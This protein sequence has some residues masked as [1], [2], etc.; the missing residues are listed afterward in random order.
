MLW[1]VTLAAVM[2]VLGWL[3]IRNQQVELIE[4]R[5]QFGRVYPI[6]LVFGILL[7]AAYILLQGEMYVQSFKS[8][9]AKVNLITAT[10]LFLKRNFV[11]I[12]LPAGGFSSLAFFNGK[13][14]QN[15]VSKTQIHVASA[16]YALCGI[17]SVLV[18]GIPVFAFAL[19]KNQLHSAELIS[20]GLLITLCA[21][22]FF[23]SA[24]LL[25]KGW[26]FLLLQRW[27]PS[28]ASVLEEL[29]TQDIIKKYFIRTLLI[30]IIIE[31]VGVAHLYISML[32]FGFQPS[33]AAAFIGYVVMVVILIVSPL[34]RGLGAIEVSLTIILGQYGL[35]LVSAASITLLFRFFEFWLP[36]FA[37]IVSFF[38]KR[39]NLTI[40]LLPAFLLFTLAV[41]NIISAVTPA[42]PK[43]LV[44]VENL[45]FHGSASV[46]NWLVLVSGFIL[47][48]ISFFLF[49][50]LRRAWY[51]ALV[52]SAFSVIGHIL[53][54]VDFEEAI[55]AL[56]SFLCLAYTRPFYKLK[57]DP[58]FTK[59]SIQVAL[60]GLGAIL[61]YGVIGFYFIDQ[62]HFGASFELMSAVKTVLRMFFLFDAR[63]VMPAT[64]LGQFFLYSIYL[65]GTGYLLII[66]YWFLRPHFAKPFNTDEERKLAS[67]LIK[68][69]GKSQLDYFK[70]YADKLLFFSSDKEGFIS[71]KMHKHMAV[72]L[73]DPVCKGPQELK[74]MVRE[75]DKYCKRNGFVSTYYRVPETSLSIYRSLNK[76]ILPVGEEAVVNLVQFSIDGR[77]MKTTRSAINRL[78]SQ[79]FVFNIYPSPIREGLLQK[80]ELVSGQWLKDMNQKEA[81]FTQGL[82]DKQALKQNTIITIEDNEDKLYAF[83]NLIPSYAPGEATYDL[84]RKTDDAPNGVLDMLLAK[85]FLYLKENKFEKVNM[86]LAP[87]SGMDG[88]DFKQRTIKYAFEK[89]IF[90]SRFKG[91]RKY[92]EKFFP[93]WEMKYLVYDHSYHL[94]QAPNY[95]RKVTESRIVN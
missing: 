20:F 82:F 65:A 49:K 23:G 10:S 44:L 94:L 17:L 2:L 74:A 66:F 76:K 72:V 41:T 28:W 75:F 1:Q 35:P 29:R 4:I 34:L 37:G 32:A 93:Q 8:V 89:S 95:L 5:K 78:T 33:L 40:R 64:Q 88:V 19:L 7:T 52:L 25:K 14:E 51:L 92:K 27:L 58:Y 81:T 60:Y 90:F 46:S 30:S 85:T 38:S 43:R 63:G 73:E 36:L 12:F 86:G 13:L 77:K 61:L 55:L 79:G 11:S 87:L 71:F 9:R 39:D 48:L 80:M 54:G 50:G 57:P 56:A 42:M 24:S 70:I 53:K 91:L 26:L 69:W 31:F 68:K 22:L 45:F 21:A 84:I 3:F 62:K 67:D 18:L 47:I 16:V 83:L 6:Y 59:V 15:G